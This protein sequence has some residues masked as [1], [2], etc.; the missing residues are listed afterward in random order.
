[1]FGI[2]LE[3]I[4]LVHE[5]FPGLGVRSIGAGFLDPTDTWV[6]ATVI[7]AWRITPNYSAAVR[8]VSLGVSSAHVTGDS[9]GRWTQ[10]AGSNTSNNRTVRTGS[11]SHSAP[12]INESVLKV[13]EW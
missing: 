6:R 5:S 7:H 1:M 4:L 8:W 12:G 9:G 13:H 2:G 10:E 3:R 11:T